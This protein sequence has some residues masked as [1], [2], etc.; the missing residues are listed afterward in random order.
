[1]EIESS[2]PH[3]IDSF[4]IYKSKTRTLFEQLVL[5]IEENSDLINFL[6]HRVKYLEQEC[7]G[8]D[9]HIEKITVAMQEAIDDYRIQADDKIE[10]VSNVIE[11]EKRSRKE[12]ERLICRLQS[13]NHRLKVQPLTPP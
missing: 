4:Q 13:E 10:E 3:N 7:E 6:E 1:M 11:M 2:T 12:C 8:K 5:K 9:L